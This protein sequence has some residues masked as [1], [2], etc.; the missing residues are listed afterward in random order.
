VL[1]FIMTLVMKCTM[2]SCVQNINFDF[3]NVGYEIFQ[4]LWIL[5]KA[6]M[7]KQKALL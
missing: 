1:F 2:M 5:L 7:R 4:I 6:K 3:L